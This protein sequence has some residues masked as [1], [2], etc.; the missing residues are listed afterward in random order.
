MA[1]PDGT[2]IDLPFYGRYEIDNATLSLEAARIMSERIRGTLRS[3]FD[4]KAK[5][6][7]EAAQWPGRC[8]KLA[9]D[10]AIYIDGAVNPLSLRVYL[11]SIEGRVTPPLVVVAAV[12]SDR[13][14][15]ATYAMLAEQADHMILTSS[16]RN[17]T[18]SF[19]D[20]ATAMAA[21]R[22]ALHATGRDI[23]V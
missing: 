8:E 3:D 7:L 1:R 9:D 13:N 19:P 20:E 16:P 12:P 4:V 14:I 17:I 23:P 15:E 6:A 5:D 22:Q 11:E 2:L 21:A 18:I 10:P